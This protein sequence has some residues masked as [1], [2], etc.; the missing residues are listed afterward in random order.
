MLRRPWIKTG[1]RSVVAVKNILGHIQFFVVV[2]S[3]VK[4]L[5]HLKEF[6]RHLAHLIIKIDRICIL[7]P[8]IDFICIVCSQ[9]CLLSLDNQRDICLSQNLTCTTHRS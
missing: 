1:Y 6:M 7:Q 4:T 3:K 5:N 2:F 9:S 8:Y